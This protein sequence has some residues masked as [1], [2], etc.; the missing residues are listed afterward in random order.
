MS[1][2]EHIAKKVKRGY[3]IHEHSW[4]YH[5]NHNRHLP[6][7]PFRREKAPGTLR[8]YN[9]CRTVY[10]G[11]TGVVTEQNSNGVGHHGSRFLIVPVEFISLVQTYQ[12]MKDYA[13]LS[14]QQWLSK[15]W[16]HGS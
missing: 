5:G 11:P 7:S 16:G 1:I 3:L 9:A 10:G 6:Y 4:I 12:N 15:T 13:G 8:I 2:E 14:L